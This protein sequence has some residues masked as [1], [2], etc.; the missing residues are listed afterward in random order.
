MVLACQFHVRIRKEP[1]KSRLSRSD[2]LA[3]LPEQ[4][5]D[6]LGRLVGLSHHR[7]TRLDED[8]PLRLSRRFHGHVCIVDVGVRVLHLRVVGALLVEGAVKLVL[9]STDFQVRP[10]YD[11]K[12]IV[13]LAD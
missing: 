1:A 7:R 10:A 13:N 12:R 2:A 8:V 4:L 5:E 11:L 6:E 9:E 3:E